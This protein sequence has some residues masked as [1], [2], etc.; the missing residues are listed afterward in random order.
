MAKQS[1][2]VASIVADEIVPPGALIE[3]SLPAA[4]DAQ[5]AQAGVRL[6]RGCQPVQALIAV[7]RQGRQITVTLP[8]DAC[9]AHRVE[10]RELLGAK[11]QRLVELLSL[12]F[13]VLAASGKVAREH[14]VEHA[15]R[16]AI[17]ELDVTR[18]APGSTG[19][20]GHVDLLKAVHRKTGE[21]VELAFDQ[22]GK[23]VDWARRMA[24]LAKRRAARYGRLHETLFDRLVRAKDDERIPVVVWP[25]IDLPP[26][27]YAKPADRRS[28]EAPPAELQVLKKLARQRVDL[29][30]ALQ[31]AKI[32]LPRAS[33]AADESPFVRL[34]A[35]PA[36][37]RLLAQDKSVGAVHYDDPTAV[38]DLGDSMAI[39]RSDLAHNAGFDGTG[40]RVAVWEDGPSDTTNLSFAARFTASPSASNHARLTSAVIKNTEANLPHGHAPDCDLY[41]ANTSGTDALQWAVR[42]Q[43]CTVVSQSFHRNSEPGGAG[44]QSDDLLKDWLALRW[45]YPTIVQAA[46]NFWSGDADNINPPEDEYVNHKGYNSLAVGNHDDTAAAMSGDS[47]FRNPSSAHGDRELP[48][49]AANG[50]S[51]SANGQTMSGTSFAAPAAAG[52]AALLQDVDGV[53]CSWPEGCRAIL[54]ASAARNVRDGSWWH[55]V[56]NRVDGRD[57]SGAVDA[58]AGVAIA[59]QRRSRNATATRRGWDVGTLASADFGSDRL[60]T[61]RYRVSVPA[62]LFQPTVKVALAWD[63][64]V[65]SILGLPI[66][67]VLTVDFDL[68]V[69]DSLGVQVASAASW[70]NSY[71]VVEFAAQRGETYEIIIR[72]WSGTDSVWYG[73]AWTTTGLEFVKS[74]DLEQ[75]RRTRLTG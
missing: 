53:L 61:F 8:A 35:T 48:E 65:T 46:G 49:I 9:G 3:F 24:E 72:R 66:A 31:S 63:S 52:V 58:Q 56:I 1:S 60:A 50:T 51:V 41:S 70:D 71:E 39:A 69:R 15:V 34:T 27:P 18:L 57:G 17:G 23:P 54:L 28:D 73:L 11:G 55:D 38:N 33:A 4:V 19:E 29:V 74:W 62:L 68:I 2:I 67:S 10:I 75:L 32:E 64:A 16:L 26:A 14:R 42:D 5:A 36:Q 44:L 45:P 6:L 22:D 47:V 12:P 43:H 40:I 7:G 59:Q 20:G 30:K 13:S 21:P 37:L 25:R